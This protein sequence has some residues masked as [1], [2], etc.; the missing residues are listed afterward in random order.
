LRH[1]RAG[2]LASRPEWHPVSEFAQFEQARIS[3]FPYEE[4]LKLVYSPGPPRLIHSNFCKLINDT[5]I[6]GYGTSNLLAKK[7]LAVG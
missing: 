7:S 2:K 3:S 5:T 4:I 1:S 6:A